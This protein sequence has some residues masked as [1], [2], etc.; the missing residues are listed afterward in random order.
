M[1]IRN[2][3]KQMYMFVMLLC[4]LCMVSCSLQEQSS[5]QSGTVKVGPRGILH[6][7]P[8]VQPK[9]ETLWEEEITRKEIAERLD[10]EGLLYSAEIVED[11]SPQMLVP[12]PRVARFVGNGF[13]IAA[14]P[15]KVEFGIIP[16]EP[17]FFKKSREGYRPGE[18]TNWGQG[19]YYAPN[20]RFYSIVGDHR[21]YDAQLYLVEYDPVMKTVQ[22]RVEINDALGRTHGEFRDGKVHGFLNF[23]NGPNIWTCTYWC[24]YPEPSEEDFNSGYSGGH[25][26]SYNIENGD[27][28]DYGAP[29]IRAAWPYCKVDSKRGMMYAVGMFNEFLAWDMNEQKTHW[30]GYLPAGMRWS[31]R[32][33]LIDEVTGMVYSSNADP[34]NPERHFI[35]YDPF[36]NRFSMLDCHIPKD[37]MTGKYN[38]LRGQTWSRGP[39]GLFWCATNHG[40]LF[41]FDPEK[42]E[43]ID[44]GRVWPG[45]RKLCPSMDR[46]PGGRYVYYT[47][48]SHG[49]AYVDGCP[50]IQYDTETGTKKVLAFLHPYYY[51]KYGYIVSGT[52]AMRLDEK[53]ERLFFCWNGGF[54]EYNPEAEP[55][56]FGYGSEYIFGHCSVMTIH[57]PESERME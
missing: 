33:M 12:H 5:D 16:V 38:P 52:Y 24:Q 11:T 45:T 21:G 55:V 1:G 30:A 26:I 50:V 56:M 49:T 7:N 32:A 44:R 18:W 20:G 40:Q 41:T 27:F 10:V 35:R 43:V 54:E 9:K 36:K 3:N 14:T 2:R 47:L 22:C 19:D 8:Q 25:I 28:V 23:Y 57:I 42:E 6:K 13:E 53:G 51:E 34:S 17:K 48:G 4:T 31:G 15:P 29:M 46:S 39:D 37:S